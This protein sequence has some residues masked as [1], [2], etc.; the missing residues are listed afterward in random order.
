[1]KK[2]E[3]IELMRDMPEEIDTVELIHRLYLKSK[4]EASMSAAEAGDVITQ[5]ELDREFDEWRE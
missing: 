2:G 4:I 1:M 5:E 3:V